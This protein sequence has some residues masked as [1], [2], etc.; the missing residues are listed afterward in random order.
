MVA[1]GAAGVEHLVKVYGGRSR[2]RLVQ[3]PAAT[4][5]SASTQ[6]PARSAS[7]ARAG[8]AS[9]R[10]PGC[11]S[12]LE[13]PTSGDRDIV[14]KQ[15]ARRPGQ[16]TAARSPDDPARLP[17]PLLV[18]RPSPHRRAASG[19]GARRPPA[20]T[21]PIAPPSASPSCSDMV[22]LG[23]RFA[24][25]YPHELSGG[26]AQRVAIARALAVEPQILV[27]DEPTSA[28]DVSVRAEVINLLVRLQDELAPVLRLHQP[29]PRHGPPHQRRH[30]G[31][32][33]GP[34]RGAT[35]GTTRCSAPSL[36]PY[37]VAL[38]DAIP[39]PDPEHERSRPGAPRVPVVRTEVSAGC[40]YAPRCP[41]AESI[42]WSTLPTLDDPADGH[43]AACFIA[44]R[45][46][47]I[48]LPRV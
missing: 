2:R 40:A 29:R 38:A 5:R 46:D 4:S 18:A 27:L 48:V 9:R 32:V 39:V 3:R 42:C 22:A 25:R 11:S 35:V 24:A 23:R 45:G 44:Q 15:H 43:Q 47:R 13:A 28:L 37:T 21:T 12:G 34:G 16:V 26:Q 31:D 17:G 36:H 30:R 19:R 33:P 10:W 14:G 41:L 7:S 1:T 8:A 20:C 6:R